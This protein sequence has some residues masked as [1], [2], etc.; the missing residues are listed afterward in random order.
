MKL[1]INIIQRVASK[2]DQI[3]QKT[4]RIGCGRDTVSSVTG[5]TPSELETKNFAE[6]RCQTKV[7]HQRK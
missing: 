5:Q 2:K 3:R 4:T 6:R 7:S 1:E